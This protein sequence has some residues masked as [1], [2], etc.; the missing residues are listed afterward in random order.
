MEAKQG[1]A[2]LDHGT[3]NVPLRKRGD[4]DKQIAAHKAQQAS[5]AKAAAKLRREKVLNA[6]EIVLG[7]SDDDCLS[8]CRRGG[9]TI[10]SAKVARQKL[11]SVARFSPTAI[12]NTAARMGQGGAA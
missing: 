5:L 3:L 7:W 9:M 6:R 10:R 4:I 8:I 12:A 2:G 11:L 1:S